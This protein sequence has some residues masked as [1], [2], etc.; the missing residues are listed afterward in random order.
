MKN[1]FK[2][3]ESQ[4]KK[5]NTYTQKMKNNGSLSSGGFF[6]KDV[7]KKYR[8][9]LDSWNK[10]F[11]A[12][13]SN[14][15]NI[16]F[17]KTITFDV[18]GDITKTKDF[19]KSLQ[20]HQKNLSEIVKNISSKEVKESSYITIFNDVYNILTN[21]K[22][23]AAF[24]IA[25]DEYKKNSSNVKG[26][27]SDI[28][29]MC[30]QILVSYLYYCMGTLNPIT[31]NGY[32][33]VEKINKKFDQNLEKQFIELLKDTQDGYWAIISDIG[34]S[35]LEISK[36]L[37]NIKNPAEEIKKAIKSQK[38]SGNK[39]ATAKES[40]DTLVLQK[41]LY[42]ISEESYLENDLSFGKEEALTVALIVIASVFGLFAL[43]TGIRRA[44]Y[45]IG[46]I[47][48]DVTEYIK[49][50]VV[51]VMMNIQS[52]KEKLDNTTDE[53]ERKKIQAIIDKQQKF[54]DKFKDKY[55]EI[56]D[57]SSQSSYEADYV[58][59]DED[60]NDNETSSSDNDY[61]ILL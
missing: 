61:D 14:S 22:H 43:I 28:L 34:F 57:E 58:I 56:A 5:I 39:L 11:V 12:N 29:I 53:K 21:Q 49:V 44:I 59:D 8:R 35:A 52:L 27:V 16:R 48:T 55:S 24:K 13:K 32:L 20:L 37:E 51:T 23:I 45:M 36:V 6:N 40:H 7:E 2:E 38:E 47:K 33:D 9:A 54:V 31:I 46:T 15:N 41:T 19:Y 42:E 50:D 18:A 17:I 4:Y 60:S 26:S 1:T 25:Y 10:Y 3:I 30:N